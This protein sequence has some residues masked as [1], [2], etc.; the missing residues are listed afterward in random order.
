MEHWKF[1]GDEYKARECI[2]RAQ[3]ELDIHR[4]LVRLGNL[5][6][7]RTERVFGDGL[8]VECRTAF[9]DTIVK[10]TYAPKKGQKVTVE[11]I[12]HP[13]PILNIIPEDDKH[14]A[15]IFPACAALSYKSIFPEG[16]MYIP[17]EYEP[18]RFIYNGDS[19]VTIDSLRPIHSKSNTVY[20]A[21]VESTFIATSNPY[22]YY[23]D[24]QIVFQKYPEEDIIFTVSEIPKERFKPVG[25]V[26]QFTG[27]YIDVAG[28]A[29]IHDAE[30][31]DD[32]SAWIIVYVRSFPNNLAEVIVATKDT[33]NGFVER[34]LTERF[35]FETVGEDSGFS[36]IK[37][38]SY[39]GIF[40][41]YGTPYFIGS[42]FN[43][44]PQFI[45]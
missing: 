31:Y 12:S 10:V 30:G 24:R 17:E 4:D 6:Q 36:A 22:I 43:P 9:N 29:I 16:S 8:I 27:T 40:D 25:A 19:K 35:F 37:T 45:G 23:E 21:R 39:C 41:Y 32:F 7:Y 5:S 11:E 38:Y 44:I 20:N 13:T 2:K 42:F 18:F 26:E 33:V 14:E 28:S 1:T 3:R 15:V 34:P